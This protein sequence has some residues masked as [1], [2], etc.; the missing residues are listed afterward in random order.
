[1]TTT[2]RTP[3]REEEE[4][5][6]APPA[7]APPYRGAARRPKR[8]TSAASSRACGR[9]PAVRSAPLTDPFRAGFPRPCAQLKGSLH[10]MSSVLE[11]APVPS[12]AENAPPPPLAAAQSDRPRLAPILYFGGIHVACLGVIWVG[13]SF[14][15]VMVCLAL[16]ALRMFAIT[17]GYHRYFSHRTYSTSRAFRFVL[18][19]LGTLAIQKGPLW[20]ASVHRHHHRESDRPAD[21]HSPIQRGFWHA[22]VGWI[23]MGAHSDTDVTRI[24]DLASA[25]ELRLL[26]RFHWVAPVLLYVGLFFFGQHLAAAHPSL[27]TSGMQLIVWGFAISTVLVYHGA[28]SVNSILHLWGRRPYK[29]SDFSRN[30]PL[31]AI[32]TFGEGWHNNHH[33]FPASERQ[34]FRWWQVDFSHYILRALSFV[35]L[36]WDLKRPPQTILDEG[37]S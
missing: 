24:P 2:T 10:R 26:D 7:S 28:W 37:R 33:R 11:S 16:Y 27:G 23:L 19:V 34:G 15:A 20:W 1:M 21:A 36:V 30:N 13:V 12:A 4:G 6:R 29:T 3:V 5:A 17:A 32:Y 8:A 25:S 35:R 14:T 22:H 31:V 18:G 9:S